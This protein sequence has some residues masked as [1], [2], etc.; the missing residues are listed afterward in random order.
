MRPPTTALFVTRW[1][2]F[3]SAAA[4]MRFD[5]STREGSDRQAFQ[6]P[7]FRLLFLGYCRQWFYYFLTDSGVEYLRQYLYLEE[8]VVPATLKKPAKPSG[9]REGAGGDRGFGGGRGKFDKEGG[10]RREGGGFRG[11]F[12]RGAGAPPAAAAAPA[13][14]ATA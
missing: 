6:R 5:C 12:G 8:N 4:H 1:V 10:Y 2:D 3:H 13:A 11:G 14:E 9:V 7:S